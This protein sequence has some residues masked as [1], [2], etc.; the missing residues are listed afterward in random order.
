MKERMRFE[1][2]RFH[3]LVQNERDNIINFLR[4]TLTRILEAFRVFIWILNY[5]I[6]CR[7]ALSSVF[8]CPGQV[9]FIE[10]STAF[11]SINKS[12]KQMF[13]LGFLKQ[14]DPKS[15]V[16]LIWSNRLKSFRG[17]RGLQ[18]MVWQFRCWD[19]EWFSSSEVQTLGHWSPYPT[20]CR[21]C[22]QSIT[23]FEQFIWSIVIGRDEGMDRVIHRTFNRTIPTNTFGWLE[24]STRSNG[25]DS[26]NSMLARKKCCWDWDCGKRKTFIAISSK[27]IA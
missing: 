7:M 27:A 25:R 18:E 1:W 19:K 24:L 4:A 17:A 20:I 9:D 6:Q 2:I 15:G 11:F 23:V 14:S 21:D 10:C 8:L 13:P 5:C 12:R 16:I 22:Q 26:F 3:E